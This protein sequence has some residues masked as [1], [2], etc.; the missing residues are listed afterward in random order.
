MTTLQLVALIAGWALA[1]LLATLILIACL[2]PLLYPQ[3]PHVPA[4]SATKTVAPGARAP[5]NLRVTQ[6]TSPAERYT[7]LLVIPCP[8]LGDDRA[9]RARAA[10]PRAAFPLHG[11]QPLGGSVDVLA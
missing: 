6:S 10:E 2:A 7:A 5:M 4:S 8:T 11:A 1:A 3:L 9:K